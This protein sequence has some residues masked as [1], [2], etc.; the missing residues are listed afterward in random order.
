ML[1]GGFFHRLFCLA[2]YSVFFIKRFLNCFPP[3]D[4]FSDLSF[5]ASFFLASVPLCL[6]LLFQ[7]LL[8]FETFKRVRVV[9]LSAMIVLS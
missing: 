4:D 1:R 9:F 2:K 6:R 8:C 7:R 3:T 5:A